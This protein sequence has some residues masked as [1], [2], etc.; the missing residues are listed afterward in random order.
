MYIIYIYLFHLLT[1][2]FTIHMNIIFIVY[3]CEK[4]KITFPTKG[5]PDEVKRMFINLDG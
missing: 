1:A 2:Y 3:N 4:K 5:F